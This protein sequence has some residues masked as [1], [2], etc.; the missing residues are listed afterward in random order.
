MRSFQLSFISYA[1]FSWK[2]TLGLLSINDIPIT[3]THRSVLSSRIESGSRRLFRANWRIHSQIH[4]KKIIH[5]RLKSLFN[6][7]K[8]CDVQVCW[9]TAVAGKLY[10]GHWKRDSGKIIQSAIL[11]N[12]PGR[13]WVLW[14]VSKIRTVYI[15]P[16]NIW[17]LKIHLAL[18][19][20]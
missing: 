1:I 6:S 10:F 15:F 8:W 16:Q 11:F 13:W 20:S 14:N 19:S 4:R 18:G 2:W 12:A 3:W 9:K 5:S 17:R 7:A